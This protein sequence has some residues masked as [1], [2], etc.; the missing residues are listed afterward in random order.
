MNGSKDIFNQ[1]ICL[2]W[3]AFL[4]YLLYDI[5]YGL[6]KFLFIDSLQNFLKNVGEHCFGEGRSEQDLSLCMGNMRD[7]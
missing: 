4:K 6:F 1:K 5:C 3:V 2:L 7:L